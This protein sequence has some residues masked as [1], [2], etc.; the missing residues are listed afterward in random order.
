MLRQAVQRDDD[1]PFAWVQLGTVYERKGDEPR[2]ALAT[3]ER[4]NLMGDARTAL[5]V[6]ISGA[7]E[8]AMLIERDA[9]ALRAQPAGEAPRER[10]GT[11]GQLD[12]VGEFQSRIDA[13]PQHEPLED[14]RRKQAA[15]RHRAQRGEHLLLDWDEARWTAQ[16]DPQ[17]ATSFLAAHED[18]K[19]ADL[20]DMLHDMSEKRRVEVASELQDER[21]AD[22]LQELPDDDQVQILSQLDIDRAADVLEE[23]DPDD[24]ADLLHELP[25]SQQELLLERM[26]PED[27]E[28]VRRLLEYEEGTAGSLM[29]PVPVILPPEATVAEAMATIRQQEISPALASLVIVARPPLETPTGRFLGVVHFQRLLRYPPPEAIGNIMDKDLEPVSDLAPI[30]HVTREL[31]TYNLTCIPVVNE[32]DRVVGAVSVDDL[33]DHILPDDWR[34]MDLDDAET[35]PAT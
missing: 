20:A 3:A 1:N 30:A 31:A 35:R 14:N 19:P 27:A 12:E 5:L 28:D 16:A 25:D 2:T 33:L 11:A 26:E 9:D 17:G 29:T 22:V 13:V 24:A 10:L 15:E 18:L 34:A 21:L 7:E 23:M 6:K 4:A 8:Q 32:Q